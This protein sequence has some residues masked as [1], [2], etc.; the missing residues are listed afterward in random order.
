MVWDD[1]S[2][3]PKVL[4]VLD[5]VAFPAT[6]LELIEHAQEHGGSESVVEVLRAMPDRTYSSMQQ[7]SRG[8]GLIE[9]LPQTDDGWWP[10]RD[11]DTNEDERRGKITQVKGHGQV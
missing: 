3:A 5:G 11:L 10:A 7:V 6:V 4:E 9:D 8:L 2:Q 1:D